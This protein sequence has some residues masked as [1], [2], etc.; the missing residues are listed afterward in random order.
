MLLPV[1]TTN[2]AIHG[3]VPIVKVWGEQSRNGRLI[4]HA[5]SNN[6]IRLLR[7]QSLLY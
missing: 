6:C 4:G 2:K 5:P 3:D 7:W 1:L